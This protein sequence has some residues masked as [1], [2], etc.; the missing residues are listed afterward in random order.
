MEIEDINEVYL[1]HF[2]NDTLKMSIEQFA[3]YL[4]VSGHT[5]WRWE[6]GQSKIPK[7]LKMLIVLLEKHREEIW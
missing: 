4:G 6:N 5:I 7:Y 2:R 1:W 3:E